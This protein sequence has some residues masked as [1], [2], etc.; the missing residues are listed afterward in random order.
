MARHERF[1]ISHTRAADATFR[2]MTEAYQAGVLMGTA[3]GPNGRTVNLNG[4]ALLNFG[5]C[6]YMSLE[7]HP[8]LRRGA[9]DAIDVY[10]TQFSFSRVLLQ[11]PLYVELESALEQITGRPAVVGA[12][13]SLVHQAAFPL[14]IQDGDSIIIDQFAHASLHTAV[15]LLPSVPMEI[16]RHNRMDLL[17]EMLARLGQTSRHI[18]Y[19]ADGLY[20]MLGDFAPFDQLRTL[21]ERHPQLRLYFDDAHATSCLGQRGRGVA[22]DQFIHDERV[23]VALS[24]NKAFAAAGGMLSLPTESLK[25][26]VRRAGGPMLFSGPIQPPMLGAALASARLH[27][28]DGFADLQQ[29][30]QSKLELCGELLAEAGLDIPMDIRSPT[31]HVQFDSPR[32]AAAILGATARDASELGEPLLEANAS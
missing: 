9:H 23:V 21:L 29:D 12:S 32:L 13:T 14:L 20:S 27:L 19:I 30:L 22:L 1:R 31:F 7:T 3:A 4:Q 18:W 17:E 11:C 6:G 28:S 8:E 25:A 5:S 10:G 26:R 15:K 16:V 2:S 24:L